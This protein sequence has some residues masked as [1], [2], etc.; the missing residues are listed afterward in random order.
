MIIIQTV[1]DLINKFLIIPFHN[2]LSYYIKYRQ[3]NIMD[4]NFPRKTSEVIE[5]KIPTCN[6]NLL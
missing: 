3:C 6:T 4:I 5:N 2:F 1:T